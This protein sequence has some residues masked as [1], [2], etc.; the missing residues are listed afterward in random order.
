MESIYLDHNATT[1]LHPEAI[2]AMTRVLDKGYANPASQHRPGQQA[3]RLLEEARET[4]AGILG[5]NLFGPQPDQLVFTSGGTEANNLAMLGIAGARSHGRPGQVIISAIEHPS[6]IGPA[7][8][9]L[10]HGWRLDSLGVDPDG[11]VY[12]QRLGELLSEQTHLVS[13]IGAN[14]ETG[15][16][17][18]VAELAA[19][20]NDAGVPLH[21]DA[22]Q[23]VGKLPV[24]FQALGVSAMSV[25]AHKFHGP[26]GIGALILRNDVPLESILFGGSQQDGVRPGTEAV[27]LAVGMAAA[28]QAW[29]EE[30][31]ALIKRITALRERFEG[32]LNAGWPEVIIHGICAPRLPQTANVAF[33]DIDGQILATTLSMAG[34]ACSTGSACASGS[35]ELSPTLLAMEVPRH[36]AASSLRFSLGSGNTEEEIDEAVCRIIHVCSE[37]R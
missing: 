32:G 17:Q 33:P 16:L 23:M 20:C 24:D 28:L 6:V 11:T 5:A 25:A 29:Q 1:P 35:T 19:I 30:Q 26:V 7:E 15:V 12:A 13:V 10:E 37:L 27:V 18:P 14:H 9:L 36:L 21:T 3:K 22:V 34:V 2:R 8:H 31:D 4:V